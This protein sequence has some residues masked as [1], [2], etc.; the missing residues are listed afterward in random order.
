MLNSERHSQERAAP[1]LSIQ[2]RTLYIE[3]VC[4]QQNHNLKATYAHDH[5]VWWQD[6][7]NMYTCG[8]KLGHF[9][10]S[11]ELCRMHVANI[12]LHSCTN[13]ANWTLLFM[14]CGEWIMWCI[15][16][17]FACI[18]Y[19]ANWSVVFGVC[20]LTRAIL[21]GFC[22]FIWFWFWFCVSSELS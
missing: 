6:G 1:W 22:I 15:Y 16:C 4:L 5:V 13:V 2:A 7:I 12:S 10:A 8:C 20:G 3:A 19:S 14:I 9:L 18:L 17:S 11:V 21:F